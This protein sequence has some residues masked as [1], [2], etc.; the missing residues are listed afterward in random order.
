MVIHLDVGLTSP[1]ARFIIRM[2]LGNKG[3]G[4]SSDIGQV[5]TNETT[6]N[7]VDRS[8][9]SDRLKTLRNNSQQH[10]TTCKGVQQCWELLANNVTSVCTGLWY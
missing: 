1:E 9:K 8:L 6:P 4:L 2:R 7:I 5:Q 10:A 3:Y